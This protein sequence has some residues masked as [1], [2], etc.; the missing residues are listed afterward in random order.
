MKIVSVIQESFL[1]YED[2]IALVLFCYG[3][4]MRCSYC[5]N[6]DHITDKSKIIDKSVYSIIGD[7]MTSLTDGLV[8]LGGEPTIYGFDLFKISDH[9]KITYGLAVKV[10]SNGSNP[11]LLF[12][13][14]SRGLFDFVSIDFKSYFPNPSIKYSGDWNTYINGVTRLLR[15]VSDN[16]YQDRFEVRMTVVDTLENEISIVKDLCNQ[17]RVN[18]ILQTDVRPSYKELGL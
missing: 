9:V 7:N 8:F 5:Y 13:G 14:L 15:L 4:N 2:Y 3:C 18:F 11:D 10:F 6:Y 12:Q 1:E 16:Q 17:N